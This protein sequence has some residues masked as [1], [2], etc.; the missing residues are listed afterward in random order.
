MLTGSYYQAFNPGAAGFVITDNV[1]SGSFETFF[2]PV[3]PL[4]FGLG[5]R[6]A[7]RELDNGVSGDLN[8]V[9]FSAQYNF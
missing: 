8:R 7:R 2:S 3:K 6:Y 5:Y 1:Y 4:T 9:Q